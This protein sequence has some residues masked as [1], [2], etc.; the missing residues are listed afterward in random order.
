MKMKKR[1]AAAEDETLTPK[2]AVILL[3]Q[4]AHEFDSFGDYGLWLQDQPEELWPL[5]RMP[6]QVV[7]AV[8]KKNPREPDEL[9]RDQFFRAQR[10]LLFLFFIYSQLNLY[11][12]EEQEAIWPRLELLSERLRS[13]VSRKYELDQKRIQNLA[14]LKNPR[15]RGGGKPCKTDVG[16]TADRELDEDLAAWAHDEKDLRVRILSLRETEEILARR[17]LGGQEILHALSK[18]RLTVGLEMLVGLRSVHREAVLAGP[19]PDREGLTRWLI[20]NW[21]A[22]K[23][24]GPETEPEPGPEPDTALTENGKADPE[25]TVEARKLVRYLVTVAK[26]E[27]L[28]VLGDPEGSVRL[29]GEWV[30]GSAG[31][32]CEHCSGPAD[33]QTD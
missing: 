9:L 18:R 14:F 29:M 21:R 10:D 31:G 32:R 26:A 1:I 13:L 27:A 2:G 4:E 33:L 17:Y 16:P 24:E 3:L 23:G 7:E 15:T 22:T 30:R 6:R 19:P 5:V 11:A 12:A 25:V 20:E 28:S 8:R